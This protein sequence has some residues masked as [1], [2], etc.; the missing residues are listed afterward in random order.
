MKQVYFSLC[1][2]AFFLFQIVPV[3]ASDIQD[4]QDKNHEMD[5]VVFFLDFPELIIPGPISGTLG[6][7]PGSVKRIFGEDLRLSSPISANESLRAIPGLHLQD[8]EGAGLRINL[9]VRGLDPDRSRNILI[10]EDGIPVA[11][12]PYGEPEMYYSPAIDRMS[13][14][15]LIKGSGQ[16]LYGPQTIGGVLN[17]I[18]PNPPDELSGQFR[19]NAGSGGYFSGYG[20]VGSS[21]DNAGF[22]LNYLYKRA[23][24]VGYVGF[25][26]HDI[27]GKFNFR[28]N[29]VSSLSLKLGI[30]REESNSTYIGLTQTMYD[31]GNQDHIL[32]APDDLLIV[33]RESASLNY[34]YSPSPNFR[35]NTTLF[36]YN[37]SRNWRRQDFSYDPNTS[38]QTGVIWGD[39]SVPGGAVFMRNSTGNRNRS[40]EVYGIEPRIRWNYDAFNQTGNELRAGA[41]FVKEVA[42]EQRVN[43]SKKDASSGFLRSDEIRTG[44]AWSAYAQNIF[45]FSKSLSVSAGIRLEHYDYEREIL[46]GVFAGESIDT[47]VSNS[48]STTALI[49]GL[50][51]NFNYS[52]GLTVFGG[53]H[54]GF[55]PPRLKDAIT[56]SGQ[57][58]ELDAELSWNTELGIRLNPQDPISGELTLFHMDFSNQIIPVS[59]SSGGTGAGLVNGGETRH[60]GAEA[61]LYL[62]LGR[63]NETFDLRTATS[64]TMM[65]SKFNSDRFFLIDEELVNAKNNRTPYAPEL[66]IYQNVDFK[67]EIGLGFRLAA[68]Y[69]SD[70]YTDVLNTTT[71]SPNGRNGLIDSHWQVDFNLFYEFS[72]QPIRLNVAVKNLTDNRYIVS[73]RPQGIRISTPRFIT[74]GVNLNF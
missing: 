31:A 40:F 17:Y 74:A 5:S 52:D 7:V 66:T 10:L 9:G 48:S 55:S 18:T 11:L 29:D 49:P 71:P 1:F 37:V 26:I 57:V 56:A 44:E 16:I 15:E 34:S 38:N 51:F 68:F 45:K 8:E 61:S 3:I 4:E 53:I 43:G 23:D 63:S 36:G 67:H 6:N 28:I 25:D 30:Y 21:S 35:L 46:R 19:L 65:N 54:R 42:Y 50:G 2:I 27:N 59:E 14:L 33:S 22:I 24:K 39:T 73:R 47:L 69:I 70:R 62:D 58:V 20:S 32:M 13:G 60:Y 64:L 72:N 12:N 41:R